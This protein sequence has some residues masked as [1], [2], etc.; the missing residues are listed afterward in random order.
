[1]ILFSCQRTADMVIKPRP[2]EHWLDEDA[3]ARNTKNRKDYFEM[4]HRAAP[5]VD[6]RAIEKRN[7]LAAMDRRLQAVMNMSEDQDTGIWRELGSRNLA[8]RMHCAAWSPDGVRTGAAYGWETSTV[9]A[10]HHWAITC[11]AVCTRSVWCRVSVGIP[12][13]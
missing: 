10:G 7:G 11:T 12:I 5:D 6:W 8:G 13:S 1:M 9:Q 2:T 4:M 3:E